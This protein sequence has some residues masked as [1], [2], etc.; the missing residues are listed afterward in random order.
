MIITI[1]EFRKYILNESWVPHFDR[2]TIYDAIEWHDNNRDL[3]PG[4]S[5]ETDINEYSD[6]YYFDTREKA[7]YYAD[8]LISMLDGLPD[9][10]PLFRAVEAD[11]AED[12]DLESPGESWSCER[13]SAYHFGLHNGSNFMI[14][15][16][17][18]KE[19]VNWHGTIKAYVL[20]SNGGDVDDEN[21]IVVDMQQELFDLRV[22]PMTKK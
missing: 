9:P 17:I 11:S 12:V 20:F 19:Y 2:Q 18:R 10:I 4:Y 15:G 3:Y 21:E 7:E 8:S 22:G 5:P 13:S 6:E 16:K 1:N 14:T